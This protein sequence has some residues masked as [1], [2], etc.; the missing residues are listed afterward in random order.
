MQRQRL[1]SDDDLSDV[2]AE[3]NRLGDDS[4]IERKLRIGRLVFERIFGSEL[5]DLE[6]RGQNHA[7][8]RRLARHS[9]LRVSV[10]T[11]FRAT[12]LWVVAQH[13]DADRVQ[14]LK[15]GHFYAV[16]GLPLAEQVALLDRVEATSMG[17]AELR[18]EVAQRRAKVA[19]GAPRP[20]R[21]PLNPVVFRLRHL[22]RSVEA[23]VAELGDRPD[24]EALSDEE[25]R[26]AERVLLEAATWVNQQLRSLGAWS[27]F[28]A[29]EVR[30]ARPRD[31]ETGSS[32]VRALGEAVNAR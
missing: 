32:G 3:L 9:G 19:N 16:C 30:S 4:E 10:A 18:R 11:V 28:A 6:R 7:S 24:F 31:N 27:R 5:V 22:G 29:P 20:G 12:K 1:I 23:C 14:R 15:V 17:V 21:T 2:V 26:E 13:L 8:F 25:R